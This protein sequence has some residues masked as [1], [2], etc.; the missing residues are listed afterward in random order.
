MSL[1]LKYRP[2]TFQDLVWQ[3]HIKITL[4]NA[5]DNDK[6]SHAYLFSGPRG[7]GKTTTARIIAKA[8]S[9]ENEEMLK[10]AD[11]WR[12]FDIIEIDAAS[13]T[14]VDSIRELREKIKFAPTVSKRKVYI[15]DEVHML[16]KG[17]F[18]ALLKTLEEPPSH[19]YFVLATTEIHKVP[20]TILSRCQYFSFSRI[21]EED[22]VWRLKVISQG[23]N[24]S[25]E[26]EALYLIAKNAEWGM[27]NAITVLEQIISVWDITV[28]N[29]EDNLWVVSSKV[30]ESFAEELM[31][32]QSKNALSLV[33]KLVYDWFDLQQFLKELLELLR[34][35]MIDSVKKNENVDRIILVIEEIQSIIPKMKITII[36]QLPLEVICVKLG[37]ENLDSV[38]KKKSWFLQSIWLAKSETKPEIV[39]EKSVEVLDKIVEKEEIQIEQKELELNLEGLKNRWPLI[40]EK[41]TEPNVRVIAK[42]AKLV[43]FEENILYIEL[44]TD[45]Y[46]NT[47]QGSKAQWDIIS[48]INSMFGR[49]IGL[50]L[51]KQGAVSLTPEVKKEI[52]DNKEETNIVDIAK[53]VFW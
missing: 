49:E 53:E 25:F 13:N 39:E 37:L 24:L 15:I 36:P 21:S 43:K 33:E 14:G 28:K 47:L 8:I 48:A 26:E 4:N 38:I 23:E 31:N 52:E 10:L 35:R 45:F 22:I 46:L 50:N 11:E 12:F 18:N 20:E 17:A 27:R 1:Y 19:A 3:A 2:K 30:V 34:E 40:V 41:M 9:C 32:G 5:I 51:H 42:S 7:T 16:S 44:A 29:V 6:L